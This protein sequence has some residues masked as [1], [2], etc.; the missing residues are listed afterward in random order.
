MPGMDSPSEWL[1][2]KLDAVHDEVTA[3]RAEIGDDRQFLVEMN[4]RSELAFQAMMR[5]LER[6]GR[7]MDARTE[8]IRAETAEILEESRA[9]TR[10]ILARLDRFDDGAAPAGGSA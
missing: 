5:E 3:I 1:R 10:A 7:R 9:H 2:A 4:R 6:F 8:E